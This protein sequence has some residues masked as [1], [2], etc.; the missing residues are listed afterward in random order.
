MV[1]QLAVNELVVG[2]S[3]TRGAD[4]RRAKACFRMTETATR[5][6][7]TQTQSIPGEPVSMKPKIWLAQSASECG[8]LVLYASVLQKTAIRKS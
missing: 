3:P 4:E 8:K 1:A 5:R 7:V 6:F 2:S